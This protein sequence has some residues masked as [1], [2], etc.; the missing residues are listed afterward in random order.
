M[1]ILMQF[2]TDLFPHSEPYGIN[3]Y[4]AFSFRTFPFLYTL[5]KG[6]VRQDIFFPD[7]QTFILN[8]SSR[9]FGLFEKKKKIPVSAS[10]S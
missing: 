3:V 4:P 6:R 9:Y 10:L 7:I 1:H 8:I 5:K 2:G